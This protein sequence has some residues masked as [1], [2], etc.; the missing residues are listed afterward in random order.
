MNVP[1][2]V[3]LSL[4]ALLG[5]A[6]AGAQQAPSPSATAGGN[7]ESAGTPA[8]RSG[9][10]ERNAQDDLEPAVDTS[11]DAQTRAPKPAASADTAHNTETPPARAAD[12]QTPPRVAAAAAKGGG[13]ASDRIELDTTSITGN[14]ELPKVMYIV[15]WKSSDLGDLVGKPV[16]SLLDEVLEPVDRDV[17]KRENR[18]YRAVATGEA[19]SSA[20]G[21][22][23]VRQGAAS[24]APAGSPG[25]R[26]ER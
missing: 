25:A 12:G 1:S 2:L 11:S 13:K 16:N 10:I 6:V 18:Y 24:S 5:S 19:H 8:P 3:T 17:F 14:R 15:H 9:H 23:A 7:A 4:A 26:D 21:A 20:G 22:G